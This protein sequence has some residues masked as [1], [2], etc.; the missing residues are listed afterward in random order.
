MT[1]RL[2]LNLGLRYDYQS[3]VP[4]KNNFGP[5]VG[6]AFDASGDG[7]T[8]IRGGGGVYYDQPFLHGF[9]QR[10]L[11]NGPQ[12]VTATYTLAA[13]ATGFPTFPNSLTGL[14]GT[15]PPRDLFLQGNNL[16]SP[17]TTQFSFG[18]QRKLFGEWVL[19]ADAI[20]HTQVKQ[21]IAYDLNAASPFPRTVN[22]QTR[23]TAVADAT[24]PLFDKAKGFSVY[25]GVPVRVVR[26]SANGGTAKY[27]ALDLG[28]RRRF[29]QRY[30]FEAHYVYSSA[31]NSLTDDHL[32]A[33]PND[34]NDAIRAE[35][36]P[37]DFH[38]RHRFVANGTVALPGRMTLTGVATLASGLP[39]NP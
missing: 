15:T 35:R 17:Y 9:T 32:S 37:S 39:V 22:G 26:E 25:Q 18:I 13:G 4:D 1:P 27:D 14:A 11:L 29:A 38:Q 7:K 5:R 33:N 31:I 34:W 16:R 28:V 8:I 20:H 21:F 30:Q 12:A 10:Y 24:R 2:T 6:F 19:T 23:T 3:I 36:G